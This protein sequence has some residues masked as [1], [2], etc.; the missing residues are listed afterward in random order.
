MS[1][2]Y[3]SDNEDITSREEMLQL[4][5]SGP[6]RQRIKFPRSILS[7]Y[8]YKPSTRSRYQ[9]KEEVI[10][11]LVTYII[12]S[13]EHISKSTNKD[14]LNVIDITNYYLGSDTNNNE[15][16]NDVIPMLCGNTVIN[17]AYRSKGDEVPIAYTA[18]K[19]P[20]I[21]TFSAKNYKVGI[22]Q[23]NEPK[24]EERK[25]Y[26][27]IAMIRVFKIYGTKIILLDVIKPEGFKL[28]NI[29]GITRDS[30][31]KLN[32]D[33]IKDLNNYVST[34]LSFDDITTI[35]HSMEEH[36]T[37]LNVTIDILSK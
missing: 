5:A 7:I 35:C 21:L 2:Y 37:K 16:K 28:T 19:R 30:N 22:Q 6:V 14:D 31:N 33:K 26:K 8:K 15:Y 4:F 29:Y 23:V 34:D 25:E 18:S 9:V 3:S 12:T 10:P 17:K 32:I 24:A 13:M 20:I 11:N 27:N 36:S 1:D